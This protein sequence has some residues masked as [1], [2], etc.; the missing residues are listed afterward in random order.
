[1]LCNFKGIN[2]E[3]IWSKHKEQSRSIPKKQVKINGFR[4]TLKLECIVKGKS[5]ENL[6]AWKEVKRLG[7]K[8]D[9]HASSEKL[10]NSSLNEEKIT[11][12]KSLQIANEKERRIKNSIKEFVLGLS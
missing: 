4:K 1:M 12:V 2:L 3:A 11:I 6:N 10:T 5:E 9:S 7:P 8:N